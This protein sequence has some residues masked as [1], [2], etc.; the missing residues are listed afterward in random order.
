[1]TKSFEVS[2]AIIILLFFV[3]F[4][5]EMHRVNYR[6]IDVPEDV[7]NLIYIKSK[8]TEFRSLVTNNNV[9]NIYSLLYNDI[10]YNFS[11]KICEYIDDNCVIRDEGYKFTRNISYYYVDLNKTLY[12][13]FG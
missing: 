5:Y 1:M 12:V 6:P 9:N 8:N 4:V 10:E 11:I 7:W 13:L 3:F 2:I